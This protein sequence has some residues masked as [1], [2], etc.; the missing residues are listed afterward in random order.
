M[1]FREAT[2][3]IY[4][5]EGAKGFMRGLA[6]SFAKNFITSGTYFSSLYYFEESLKRLNLLSASQVHFT[7]ACLARTFQSVISNPLI[8]IKTR[9]EV[10]GFNEYSSVGDAFSKFTGWRAW[11]DSGRASKSA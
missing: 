7:A 10:A 5:T 6:P 9:M 2:R 3:H 1:K 8:V 4:R 11:E